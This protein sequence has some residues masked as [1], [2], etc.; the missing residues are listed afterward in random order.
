MLSS[1]FFLKKKPHGTMPETPQEL[2]NRRKGAST[3]IAMPGKRT[4][5]DAALIAAYRFTIAWF[6]RLKPD[7]SNPYS[8][9]A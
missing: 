7:G 9:R 2:E 8:Q 3:T 5:G 1:G 6:G 4:Q